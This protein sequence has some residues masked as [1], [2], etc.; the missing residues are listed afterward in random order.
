MVLG[1][2]GSAG[3]ATSG[4]GTTGLL[5]TVTLAASPSFPTGQTSAKPAGIQQPEVYTGGFTAEGQTNRSYSPRTLSPTGVPI[6]QPT[7]VNGSTGLRKSFQGLD[8][9]EERY[10]NNGNQFTFEPPDQGMCVGNGYVLEQVNGAVRAYKTSGTPA[11]AVTDINT[12]YG[13]PAVINRT[14]GVYGPELT[15]PSCI[16]DRMTNRFY[17]VVLTLETNSKTGALTLVNHLDLAVS[18]TGNPLGRYDIYKLDVTDNGTNG[19]PKHTSCPCLGDYPHIGADKYGIYLTTN[20]Y[21]FSGS[22]VYGNGFNGAQIYLFDK[23]ALARGAN[24][25]RVAQ[26]QNTF[27]QNGTTKIP[28]FTV[29]P[30]N[31]PDG[32]FQTANN[33]TEYFL[34][35]IAASEAMGTGTA[36]AIAVWRVTNSASIAT[37]SPS[38]RLS[39]SLL[40]S[41]TYVVPPRSNQKPGP[42]PLGSYCAVVN[43]FGYGTSDGTEGPLDSN[44]TRMQQVYYANGRLYSALDT[45][46]QVSG[47][48]KAGIAW[49]VVNPDG[50]PSGA[51][52]VNQGYIGVTNN[53]VTY[54]A[55]A[56]NA[57]GMGAMAFTLVGNSYYPSAGYALMNAN[58]VTGT[59]NVAAAGAGPQDGFTE[60]LPL[61]GPGTQ[62]RPR[63]GDYGAAQPVGSSIWLASEYIGQRCSFATFQHDPTCGG[64]RAPFANW[65]TRISQVTP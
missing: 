20:E 51:T 35:S 62:T 21:P 23:Q 41:E 8:A 19:S 27:V 13:Y 59:V 48:L 37:G 63:W 44:D 46:V 7:A 52:M 50:T 6:V 18:Q 57:A 28:G 12:F 33:G 58:G 34:S 49:F 40:N 53:N 36:S 16:Y 64:T 54:P 61:N 1:G 22:G 14:T 55:T 11:S 29:W 10:A 39:N 26:F 2:S 43:C 5:R 9:Y 30:A 42:I 17:V 45:A 47:N 32:H 38:P 60:Y 31:V 15:D 24:S 56:V 4:T 25:V 3:A 65:G